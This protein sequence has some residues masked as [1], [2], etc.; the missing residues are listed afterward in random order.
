MDIAKRIAQFENMAQ[1]DAA[2]EMAHFS[3]GKAYADAGRYADAADSFIRCTQ[4]VPDMSKAFQLAGEMLV[5][6]GQNDRAIDVLS[7]GYETAAEKGDLMPRNAMG[8]LLKELGAPVPTVA[9]AAL[10]SP[11]GVGVPLGSDGSHSGPVPPGMIVD[12]STGRLGTKLAKPPFKG[13][14][15]AWIGE[16]VSNETWQA[17]I[18]QG[19]KVI[20]ELRLDL[21]REKDAETYDQHMREYLGIDDAVLANLGVAKT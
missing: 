17:W 13:A 12:K 19:T 7:R 21:S 18:R 20:N 16:N 9:G 3:L 4:L 8:T 1:A 2:N 5:K 11:V 10:T 14:I 15:G 6:A